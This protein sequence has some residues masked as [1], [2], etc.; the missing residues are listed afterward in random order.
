MGMT[1][2]DT[3]HDHGGGDFAIIDANTPY[4]SFLHGINGEDYFSFAFFG[5]GEN[6]ISSARTLPIRDKTGGARGVVEKA[7]RNA[8]GSGSRCDVQEYMR[9]RRQFV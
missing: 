1:V 9:V 7:A 6:S 8:A 5:K 4:P 2:Y 3:H